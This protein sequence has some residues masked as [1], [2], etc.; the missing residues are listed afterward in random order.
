MGELKQGLLDFDRKEPVCPRLPKK[1][2]LLLSS[3][4]VHETSGYQATDED[5]P[6]IFWPIQ[7]EGKQ[8]ERGKENDFGVVPSSHAVP[9]MINRV[10]LETPDGCATGLGVASEPGMDVGLTIH[11]HTEFFERRAP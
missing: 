7:E 9:P 1:S 3:Y 10:G 11:R 6:A 8:L 4:E 5:L 2:R